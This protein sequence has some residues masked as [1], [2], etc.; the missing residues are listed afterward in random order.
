M[1]RLRISIP[2]LVW[3]MH[4]IFVGNDGFPVPLTFLG[5]HGHTERARAF[6]CGMLVR[7]MLEGRR[8]GRKTL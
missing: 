5:R 7:W 6:L 1:G 3:G 8:K 4:S 2:I